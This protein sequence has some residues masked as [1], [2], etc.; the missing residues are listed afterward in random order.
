ML[1]RGSE[2]ADGNGKRA[3]PGSRPSTVAGQAKFGLLFALLIFVGV[4]AAIL[5]LVSF[6]EPEG[7][8]EIESD[9]D[10]PER[11]VPPSERPKEVA[12]GSRAS[13][14]QPQSSVPS[15]T[16][17]EVEQFLGQECVVTWEGTTKVSTYP[18]G[19]VAIKA[20]TH[21][22]VKH[23]PFRAWFDNG[24]VS[25][26]G[27]YKGGRRDGTW[28]FFHKNGQLAW[29]GAYTEGQRVGVWEDY[30]PTGIIQSLGEYQDGERQG[31]W[32]FYDQDGEI[33]VEESGV[34]LNGELVEP[35]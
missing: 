12:I 1:V 2:H 25:S 32:F 15:E 31:L 10:G 27:N 22:G 8:T 21:L 16:A 17:A 4:F 3:A 26:E 14:E 28:R 33:D 29:L 6:P 34:F 5:Y 23:G 30:Y 13:L 24:H 20:E 9:L 7:Q 35:L 18:S 11:E 19:Q